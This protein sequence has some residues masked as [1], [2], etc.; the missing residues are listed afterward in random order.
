LSENREQFVD[1][2]FQAPEGPIESAVA[3]IQAV[4]LGVDRV[5]R[6]DSFYDF[7]GT[8]LQ[9]IRI[10]A[11]IERETG[12]R[13]LPAWLFDT[14][15]LADFAGRLEEREPAAPEPAPPTV[16]EAGGLSDGQV[17]MWLDGLVRPGHALG[18]V[19]VLAYRLTPAPP[20]QALL[21]AL[22]AFT[23]R[24][25][26]LVTA[27]RADDDG[28]PQPVKLGVADALV[29]DRYR[30]EGVSLQARA[31]RLAQQVDI[32]SGP[33]V[34]ARIDQVPGGCE[35]LLAF[36]HA[37]F[38]GH[39]EALLSAELSALSRA[40]SLP[41][42]APF[43]GLAAAPSRPPD[44]DLADWGH[45]LAATQD[46]S[47][48]APSP[49]N[50]PGNPPGSPSG[51]IR[52]EV[53]A[54]V[55]AGLAKQA[56]T[57]GLTPFVL[58]LRAV[59]RAVRDAS[60]TASFCVGV[61]VSTRDS[62]SDATVGNF[63]RQVVVPVGPVELD[64]PVSAIAAS[65]ERARALAGVG[66][67]EL[68][69]LAGRGASERSRLFQVQ[70]AWQNQPAAV[71]SIP[72]VTVTD[73]PVNPLVPQFDLTVELRPMPAGTVSGLIEYDQ[74]TVAEPAAALIAGRIRS[75]FDEGAI[76]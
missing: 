28:M 75:W 33:L 35:L 4:V 58:V 16:A 56:R 60:A 52:F 34:A 14:D 76:A 10:C 27:V 48:P 24:H 61:P 3:R 55:A 62:E 66:V 74:E 43:A 19:V 69:R 68:A 65:W 47:W 32:E 15:V 26:A 59:G 54:D 7:G 29:I 64:G 18:N 67:S 12:R 31:E 42:A 39:S 2:E 44:T 46:V 71:W 17:A 40:E 53:P 23:G 21:D 22:P 51:A 49:G 41:P 20:E 25:D 63:V 72:S 57:A 36:H 50:P 6:T 37:C 73:L 8:S 30:A 13:A 9:A 1:T 70:F 45:R 38:D 5:G 11:R